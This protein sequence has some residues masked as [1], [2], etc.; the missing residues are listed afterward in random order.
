MTVR[1]YTSWWFW[2]QTVVA[3]STCEAEYTSLRVACK[4]A[5]WLYRLLR[6]LI[7]DIKLSLALY[8]NNHSAVT[9]SGTVSVN[10]RNTHSDITNQYVFDAVDRK[11]V[12]YSI[13]DS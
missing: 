2:K 3:T 1:G 7:P 5:V 9:L 13:C 11:E 12:H 10:Q 8:G 4:N 6:G